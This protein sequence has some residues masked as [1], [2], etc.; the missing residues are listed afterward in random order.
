MIEKVHDSQYKNQMLHNLAKLGLILKLLCML[1]RQTVNTDVRLSFLEKFCFN[2]RILL[3]KAEQ[4]FFGTSYSNRYNFHGNILYL[5]EANYS[6]S[7]LS[8][9]LYFFEIGPVNSVRSSYHQFHS[10]R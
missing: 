2:D 6:L 5:A 8:V 4:S 7:V 1:L 9:K 10:A 3:I